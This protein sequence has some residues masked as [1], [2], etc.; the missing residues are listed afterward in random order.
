[1]FLALLAV[2]GCR[3][4]GR[5]ARGTPVVLISVDTL[6]SDRLPCYGY[7]G[8]E[9]PAI[10]ALARDS[11][12]FERAYAHVPWTLPSHVSIL[13][14]L[15]PGEHGV[16]DNL[17]YDLD[18]EHLPL[19]QSSLKELG[20][21]TGA[22]VSAY[23]LRGA[24]GLATG[25]DWYEDGIEISRQTSLAGLWRAGGETLRL[26]VD[27]VRSVHDR[28]F[29]LFFHIYEPHA[30]H[31]PP[32]A[33]AGRFASP[34]D[35]EVAAADAV[36]GQL[37]DELRSLEIYDR[38]VIVFVS[39]HGEGL[40]DH[41]EAEHGVFLYRSTLQVPL[42][43]KLPH[44]ERAGTHV[45]EPAQLTDIYPTILDL[46]DVP[47]PAGLEGVSLLALSDEGDTGRSIYAETLYRRLHYGW[48]D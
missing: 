12:L 42:L 35:G 40:G 18:K 7:R 10:D 37:L 46:L 25:F 48:S 33:F 43:L 36:V 8:G 22:A 26:A 6:R 24:T 32:A 39:D 5:I 17:G 27:W 44:G 14:G 28:P 29:F 47:A 11:I 16:R 15:L 45:P 3:P 4:G 34:Y 21:A 9:T 30:P 41:D 20:Y 13:T 23:V 31:A 19:L 38:A 2:L 1:V